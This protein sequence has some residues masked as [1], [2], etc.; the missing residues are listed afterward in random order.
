MGS[1]PLPTLIIRAWWLAASGVADYLTGRYLP[2]ADQLAESEAIFEANSAGMA[3]D[4]ASVRYYL[5]QDLDCLG[6]FAKLARLVP[7]HVAI[8]C[9][10]TGLIRRLAQLLLIKKLGSWS[11][12]PDAA[13]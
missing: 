2:A 1:G 13:A 3:W 10:R 5:L 12:S 8:A 4:L 11:S 7:K 6:H 9:Q